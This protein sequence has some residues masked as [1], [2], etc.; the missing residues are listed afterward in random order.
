MKER[1]PD[2]IDYRFTASIEE[3][4]DDIEEGSKTVSSLLSGFWA[5]FEVELKA[6]EDAIGTLQTEVPPEETDIV[7]EK[8]GATM[9]VRNGRYGKFAACP[10]YPNCKNTKPLTSTEERGEGTEETETVEK[11]VVSAGFKCELCGAEMVERTGRYGTFF[12]CSRYP[13][14]KNTKQKRRELGVDCPKCGGKVLIKVGKSRTVFY[15]CEHYPTCDF[16]S[17]DMPLSEKCPDCGE[18]LFRKKGKN[19]VICHNKSCGYQR[20]EAPA[21][22]QD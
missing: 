8:C 11:K 7:C 3:G 14:C 13:E 22:R 10:N 17:W 19:L 5:D 6:A 16:S 12:A 4:L 1:F 21:E 15:S 9:I 20:E 2:I 18:T